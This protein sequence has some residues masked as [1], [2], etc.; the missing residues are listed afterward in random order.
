MFATAVFAPV[1][2][3]ATQFTPAT[4]AET[5]VPAAQIDCDPPGKTRT[6]IMRAALATP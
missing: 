1:W 5:V 3:L 2:L 4:T 6:G